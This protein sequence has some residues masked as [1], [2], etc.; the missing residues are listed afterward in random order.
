MMSNDAAVHD[1]VE[2][3]SPAA[4]SD[5]EHILAA[6]A[7]SHSLL[8]RHLAA[9]LAELDMQPTALPQ[10]LLDTIRSGLLCPDSTVGIYAIDAACYGEYAPLFNPVIQDCHRIDVSERWRADTDVAKLALPAVI[11]GVRSSRVRCAR[12]LQ[13]FPFGPAISAVQRKV[14]EATIVRALRSLSG[15]PFAATY[16]SLET[17]PRTR[18]RAL[19]RAHWL[20]EPNDRYLL[21]AGFYRDYPAGRGIYLSAHGGFAVLVNDEDA[22]RIIAMQPDGRL[23]E[24]AERL[25][26]LEHLLSERLDFA[27][28]E[29][30]GYLT[31][32]PSNLGTAMR[33][34]VHLRLPRFPIDQ[35]KDTAHSL[36]LQVR[37][38]YGEHDPPDPARPYD[39]S[40]R[41][42]LGA[43]EVDLI[44][45]LYRGIR[46]LYD[47]HGALPSDGPG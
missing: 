2:S 30:L 19:V 14:L 17:M 43:T 40:N 29:H 45:Q 13:G 1:A 24:V 42:R 23:G 46:R 15:T 35:L 11:P 31:S 12:N 4:S 28:D 38:Q 10:R 18:Y 33:A 3:A 27:R 20:S 41:Q 22:L 39:F 6:L 9:A 37:G 7:G 21:S 16:Y 47:L 5:P 34:S 44:N 36:G 26:A 8:A 25:F 32:C